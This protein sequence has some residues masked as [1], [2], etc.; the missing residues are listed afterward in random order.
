M[1]ERRGLEGLSEA[2]EVERII[3]P[4]MF[5]ARYNAFRGAI[6]GTSS[7]SRFAAFRR[8]PNRSRALHGLYFAGGSAHPG[9]GIPLVLLSGKMAG[10]LAAEDL[11]G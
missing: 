5:A 10:E 7:N 3:T 9:G 8:P 1:L 11:L 6:Y 4:A 2:I